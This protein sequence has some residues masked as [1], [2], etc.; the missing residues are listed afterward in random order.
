MTRRFSP[1]PERAVY[2]EGARRLADS[3]RSLGTWPNSR[4]RW[5][6]AESSDWLPIM[7]DF[8][9]G[10]AGKALLFPRLTTTEIY[11]NLSPGDVMRQFLEKWYPAS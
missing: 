11:L 10:I 4:G 8:M 9:L 3:T 1:I 2:A 5:A 6:D 7:T